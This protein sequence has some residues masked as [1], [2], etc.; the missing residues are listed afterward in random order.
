MMKDVG[1]KSSEAYQR[2]TWDALK[3]SINGLVNKVNT[4]NLT[5]I[6]PELFRENLVRG[7]GLLS[8][9]LMKSQGASPGF[10]HVFA[11]LVAVLNTKFPENGLLLL[12]RLVLQFRRSF[13]R[14]DKVDHTAYN[15]T[16]MSCVTHTHT[17]R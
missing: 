5:N 9:S 14:N 15:E 1:D 8:R 6:L 4:T 11:G 10:T 2:L 16:T 17:H 3:K 13:K 7:R 12:H